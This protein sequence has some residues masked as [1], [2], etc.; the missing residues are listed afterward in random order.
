MIKIYE[1]KWASLVA[2]MVKNLTEMQENGVRS[3][4]QEDALEKG[5]ATHF[6]ILAWRIPWTE[7]PV[8]PQSTGLQRVRHDSD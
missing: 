3:L 5:M 4:S 6:G 8:R 2:K 7:E 1:V